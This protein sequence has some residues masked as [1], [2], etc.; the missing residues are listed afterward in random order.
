[1][2]SHCICLTFHIDFDEEIRKC[3]YIT[4][5]D[6]SF[7]RKSDKFYRKFAYIKASLLIKGEITFFTFVYLA[8]CVNVQMC[9]KS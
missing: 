1:M 9:H 7:F 6:V 5:F 2:K 3:S 4:S 8:V